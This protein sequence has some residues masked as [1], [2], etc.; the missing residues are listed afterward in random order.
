MAGNNPSNSSWFTTTNYVLELC[1]QLQIATTAIFDAPLTPPGLTRIQSQARRFVDLCDR[2]LNDRT[3]NRENRQDFQILTYT[4]N[5][6]IQSTYTYQLPSNVRIEYLRYTSMFNVTP[7]VVAENGTTTIYAQPLRNVPYR[8]FRNRFPD[9]TAITTGPPQWWIILPKSLAAAGDGSTGPGIM[10]DSIMFYPIP[11]QQYTLIYECGLKAVP[12]ALS[13]D[14]ILFS[15]DHEHIVWLM[16]KAFTEDALGDGKG[17]NTLALAEDVVSK[18]LWRM[19]GPEEERRAIRTG[20]II[21]GPLKGRRVNPYSDTPT[22][23]N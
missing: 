14:P 13:T 7:Q 1:G 22:S 11:D 9:F 2:I 21:G 15:Q 20:M 6:L 3:Y 8:E 19:S 12:L 4:G 16:A 10:Y 5:P 18:Y 17:Q 23:S